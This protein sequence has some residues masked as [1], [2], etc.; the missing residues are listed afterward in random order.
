[1][2]AAA[3]ESEPFRKDKSISRR[4]TVSLILTVTL[5]SVA[6]VSTIYLNTVRKTSQELEHKADDI[7]AHQVSLLAIPLWDLDERSIQAIGKTIFQY[8]I[9]AELV[10]KDYLGRTV[11]TDRKDLADTVSR[12]VPIYHQEGYVGEVFVALTTQFNQQNNR[13]LLF[14][15]IVTIILILGTL[16]VVSGLLV[17]TFLRRP[18]DNLNEVVRSYAAGDYHASKRFQ[19]YM[20]FRPFSRVLA[21]MGDQI[22]SQMAALQQAE[23][24]Y[25][26]IFEN[27]V[28]GIFQSTPEGNFLSVNPSMAE[29]LGFRSPA[30]L[31]ES[32]TDIAAQ[33]YLRPDDR[34]RFA[35]LMN[36]EGRV[37]DFEAQMRRRD[38]QVITGLIS[39]RAVRDVGSGK[40]YY[41][42]SCIDITRRKQASEALRETTEQLSLLLEALPIVSLTCL[43]DG[44]FRITFISN[45]IEEITGYKPEQFMADPGFWAA[46]IVEEDRL[47]VLGELPKVPAAAKGR[48]EYRFQAADGS[49]RW[50]DDT[51]R[52]VLGPDGTPSHIAGMWRDITEEKR[53]RKEA[54]YRLQQVIQRD[55]LASLGVVVAGV[56]HEINNPNSFITYNVPLLEETWRIFLPILSR[57]GEDHPDWRHR[58]MDMEELCGDMGEILAAI[59]T[60]SDRIN[61]IVLDLKEFVRMEQ[62]PLRP[63]HINQVIEKAF[64]L[65]GA[66]VRKS[67]ARWQFDL[68]RNLPVFQGSFQ[69]LEQVVMNLVVNALYAIPNKEKGRLTI[70]TRYVERLRAN[71][72]SVEDNG[73]GIEPGLEERIFEP[74]FTSRREL[75]GTGIGLSV[76]YDL[77]REHNGYIRVLS[78]LGKGSR[79]TVYLPVDPAA[80]LDLRSVVLCFD[81]DPALH[82]GLTS[83][84]IEAGDILLVIPE[85]AEEMIYRIEYWPE[86]EIIIADVESLR[87]DGW[88]MLAE[89]RERF[90]LLTL[91][92]TAS[93]AVALTEMPANIPAPDHVLQKPVQ[94]AALAEIL[95]NRRTKP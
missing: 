77:V 81:H 10:I 31:I 27:A 84:F 63:I 21:Q 17:R 23:E 35:Q 75:G 90:P 7:V 32:V 29:M 54:E 13:K 93:D 9:V 41:E 11:F 3:P 55:K 87:G 42:G 16:I 8:D 49:L 20:E 28:E 19:P 44:D 74:F 76:S 51:R 57:F 52:L 67:V 43:P 82:R 85:T 59:K 94:Q 60:G 5:V 70:A 18:L 47:Q 37:V 89:V 72:I 88:S 71:I 30:D 66:Q 34:L 79:F 92:V 61:R 95:Q 78:K 12:S 65:V 2:Q 4:L 39:A 33:L 38:G 15:F 53:L 64:V 91:I 80:R 56:A 45:T 58:A 14:S 62:G 25:R 6:T 50:F 22:T 83:L 40:V 26:G 68:A 73:T 1:M 86:A 36:T 24:K 69:K 48:F 46:R